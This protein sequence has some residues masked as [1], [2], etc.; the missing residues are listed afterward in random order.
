MDIKTIELANYPGIKKLI[1][2]AFPDYRKKKAMMSYFPENGVQINS[3][4]DGGS[5]DEF[6]I[7]NTSGQI[8]TLPTSHPEY[9]LKGISGQ[10]P[11]VEAVNGNVYL[12]RLPKG[13]VLI[14]SG[15]FCGKPA[16]AHVYLSREGV[17]E[18]LPDRPL[19]PA[20]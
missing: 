11:D 5:K 16:T 7:V 12:R 9:D 3:Y 10:T 19:L 15:T 8:K 14:R 1:V 17:D 20:G 2:C 13:F 4:W 18:S 6:V